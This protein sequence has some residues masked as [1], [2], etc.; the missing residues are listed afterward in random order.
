M[1]IIKFSKDY[2]LNQKLNKSDLININKKIII[3]SQHNKNINI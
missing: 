2:D 3:S 1:I